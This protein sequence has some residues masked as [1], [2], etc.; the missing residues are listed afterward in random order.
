[1]QD[2]IA[3]RDLPAGRTAVSTPLPN[4]HPPTLLTRPKFPADTGF[5]AEVRRRV[6]NYFKV[7][8]KRERDQPAMYLKSAAILAWLIG[9]WALL[10]FAAQTWWQALPL[11]V[12][13]ALAMAA[14]G[15]SIQHDGGHNAYS[16]RRWVNKLAA[17]SLD[18]M[19]ASSYLWRWKHH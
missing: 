1:M 19:G 15:F 12:A 5:Q 14:L 8:G 6:D 11:A 10:V 9:S 2:A 16:R 18:M 17:L 13:L 3:M 7:T 4:L